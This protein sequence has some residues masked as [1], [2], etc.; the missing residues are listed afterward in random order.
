MSV[1]FTVDDL[2]AAI[3]RSDDG[4]VR[5]LLAAGVSPNGADPQESSP[6]QL[7]M[8]MGRE[9]IVADL[10]AA[11]AVFDPETLVSAAGLNHLTVVRLL[12]AGPPSSADA[13]NTA[14]WYAARMGHIP[15][16]EALL[17][18]GAT[19]TWRG[20]IEHY[21]GCTALMV[22][23][24]DCNGPLVDVL[25]AGGSDPNAT[26][27]KGET[28]LMIAAGAETDGPLLV[29]RLLDAGA[30]PNAV[31]PNGGT[32]LM[33]A[34]R[35]NNVGAL[36]QLLD[37]GAD[38]AAVDGTGDNAVH[39]AVRGGSD[40]CALIL[41]SQTTR[42]F[43]DQDRWAH[44]LLRLAAANNCRRVVR[45]LVRW[46]ACVD[47]TDDDAAPL[48]VAVNQSRPAVVRTLLA[49]GADPNRTD[50]LG[51]TA[52][53]FRADRYTDTII[54]RMLLEAGADPCWCDA[55]GQTALQDHPNRPA[56]TLI[57]HYQNAQL[58]KSVLTTMIDASGPVGPARVM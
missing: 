21:S 36:V 3:A 52:L 9:S 58:D 37:G 54:A 5:S 42:R 43:N 17:Q 8:A 25:L 51:R 57:A 19:D 1:A 7:A 56:A 24:V 23:V 35:N 18:A 27:S 11:G 32:A 12:A 31:D 49:L 53:H 55:Q 41:L 48:I 13:I 10:L 39:H 26:T 30:D 20:A 40:A 6:L 22:A 15:T 4:A 46:G 29:R 45:H 44:S 50:S 38:G 14:L 2:F 34:A 47:G 28:A 33:K 16:A